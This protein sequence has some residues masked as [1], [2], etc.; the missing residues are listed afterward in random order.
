[1]GVGGGGKVASCP[2]VLGMGIHGIELAS[3]SGFGPHLPFA[4]IQL[5]PLAAFP[6]TR[7][8]RK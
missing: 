8:T 4:P 6:C 3:R 7:C 5:G 1:M 2:F